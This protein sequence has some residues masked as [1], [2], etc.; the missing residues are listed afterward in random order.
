MPLRVSSYLKS[1]VTSFN[2][3]YS[4]LFLSRSIAKLRHPA[5]DHIVT[6]RV[7][8]LLSPHAQKCRFGDRVWKIYNQDNSSLQV[9][10]ACGHQNVMS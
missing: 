6:L 5:R 1:Y 10:D 3:T 2:V 8:G 7:I 9:L 4:I